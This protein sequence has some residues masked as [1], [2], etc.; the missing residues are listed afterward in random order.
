MKLNNDLD[1]IKLNF[2]NSIHL[3]GSFALAL[4]FGYCWGYIVGGITS[5]GLWILW[6]I[7]DGMKPHWSSYED[8][9]GGNWIDF[10]RK[11]LLFA[12]YFSFQDAFV[13]DL[14]GAVIG[15][16]FIGVYNGI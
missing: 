16:L 11:E 13:W 1:N 3:F 12:D 6:E 10:L 8:K 15:A 9:Y 2:H 5:Y 7:C 14:W 4:V